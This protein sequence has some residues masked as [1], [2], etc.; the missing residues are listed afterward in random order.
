MS[1]K[2]LD[3]ACASQ[4][5]YRKHAKHCSQ[6]KGRVISAFPRNHLVKPVR[7]FF[8]KTQLT[9]EQNRR[10]LICV[11]QVVPGC[12]GREI[13]CGGSK[14]RYSKCNPNIAAIASL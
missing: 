11:I 14:Q 7:R 2:A 8:A 6:R 13:K 1:G 5:R 9:M 12:P 4:E 3:Q 10:N